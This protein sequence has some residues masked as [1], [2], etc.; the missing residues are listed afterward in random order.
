MVV[1]TVLSLTAICTV[2][3]EENIL[4][5]VLVIRHCNH[6]VIYRPIRRV[7]PI[8]RSRCFQ[9]PNQESSKF[10]IGSVMPGFSASSCYK[11][12]RPFRASVTKPL[13]EVMDRM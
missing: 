9:A 7:A 2:T 12:I 10:P 13:G 1:N 8:E 4:D 3:S 11:A 6:G 5:V